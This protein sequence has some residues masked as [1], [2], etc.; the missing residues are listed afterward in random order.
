MLGYPGGSGRSFD[1]GDVHPDDDDHARQL[2]VG[3]GQAT[4][5][6]ATAEL[7]V[8]HRDGSWRVID[9][10]ATNRLDDPAVRGIVLNSHDV[11]DRKRLEEQL[12][13][14]AFHDSLTG[15][16]NRAPVRGPRGA[17]V[18]PQS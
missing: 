3:I 6:Q 17:R 13:E 16:A 4:R 1:A 10:V 8:R 11:T 7:R 9:V 14:Q 2:L 15:L 18:D 5:G 12:T